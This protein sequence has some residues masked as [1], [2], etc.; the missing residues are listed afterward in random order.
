MET[1]VST[2]AL[3]SL[4]ETV[5]MVRLIIPED[6]GFSPKPRIVPLELLGFGSLLALMPKSKRLSIA[7]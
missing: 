4:G 5:S 7:F 1:D 6:G 2:L 3:L